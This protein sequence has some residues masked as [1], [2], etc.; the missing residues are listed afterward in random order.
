MTQVDDWQLTAD[1]V[2]SFSNTPDQ[3]LKHILTELVQSSHDFVRRT[4]LTFEEWNYAI[5]YLARTGHACTPARQEFVLLADVLGISMLVDAINHRERDGATPTTVL[6]PFYVGE[7]KLLP[8]GSNISSGVSGAPMF[9]RIRVADVSGKPIGHAIVDVWHADDDGLYDSQKASYPEEG[10]SLRARF[11]VDAQGCLSFRT[12]LPCSYPIPTDGPVGELLDASARHPMRPAHVHFLVAAE[13]FEPLVTHVF[14]AGDKNL[15]SDA[16][17]G[18]KSELI[19]HLEEHDES[20]MPD[21]SPANGPWY[22]L[23]YEFRMQPG[24]GT[25]P[26]PLPGT[27]RA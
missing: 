9:V 10:P 4:N 13:G 8:H 22:V 1:V 27:R 6:G 21:G 12:I 2:R 3:R 24:N 16:V 20:P 11:A 15:E 14:I 17:F 7:H 26:T 5:D 23:T 19:S 25:A 18:V